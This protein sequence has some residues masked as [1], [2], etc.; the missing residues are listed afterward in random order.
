MNGQQECLCSLRVRHILV[1]VVM[2][3]LKGMVIGGKTTR[4]YHME[5]VAAIFRKG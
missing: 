3:G 1:C 4:C 2:R 5:R